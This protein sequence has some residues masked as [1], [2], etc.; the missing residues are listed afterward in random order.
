MNTISADLKKKAQQLENELKSSKD[1][2][3]HVM[4]DRGV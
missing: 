2:N 4:E 3:R 1:K